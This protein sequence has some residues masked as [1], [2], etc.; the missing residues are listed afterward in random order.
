MRGVRMP[1]TRRVLAAMLALVVTATPAFAASPS[2]PRREVFPPKL[3]AYI[4]KVLRDWDLPGA[5]VAVVKDGRVVVVKGYGVRELGRPEPVD[6]N[7][8]FDVASLTK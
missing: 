1:Q 4:A 6:E 8:I 3:D 7:T 5:A 2:A